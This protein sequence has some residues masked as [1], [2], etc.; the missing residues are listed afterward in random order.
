MG[1]LNTID[2][3]T[4]AEA[5]G[6]LKMLLG[7][8]DD[9]KDELLSFLI[10]DAEQLI[11]GYCRICFLPRQLEGLLPMIAADVYRAKGYG[12]ESAPEVVK[13]V[14]EGQRSVSF[15]TTRQTDIGILDKFHSRLKPYI[16]RRGKV[17]SDVGKIC[18]CV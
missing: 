2:G 15:E 16:N 6:T 18:E 4:K 12:S 1:T 7:I 8:E 17:P 14:S 9:G 5:L 10:D 11:L 13:S 3:D